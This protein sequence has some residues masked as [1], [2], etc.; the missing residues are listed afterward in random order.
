MLF[1]SLWL[2]SYLSWLEIRRIT[3]GH[4]RYFFYLLWTQVSPGFHLHLMPTGP[5]SILNFHHIIRVHV[6]NKNFISCPGDL[7]FHL[8]RSRLRI[9]E[10][11]YFSYHIIIA[12]SVKMQS[13]SW[14]SW[15]VSTRKNN[16][17][18]CHSRDVWDGHV[19]QELFISR[20]HITMTV[21]LARF[22]PGKAIYLARL[23]L[24]RVNHL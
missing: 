20:L 16:P 12:P 17:Q 11:Y 7:R 3:I 10:L 5:H 15:G 13:R 2:N 24:M 9:V 8:M 14:N 4:T 18:L 23:H 22:H 1:S 21:H 6:S 19:L